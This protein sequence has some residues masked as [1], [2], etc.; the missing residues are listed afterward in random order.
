MARTRIT[1]TDLNT[2]LIEEVY[3]LNGRRHRDANEGPAYS[4]CYEGK[5]I[6]EKYYWHG[7]L[8]RVDGPAVLVHNDEALEEEHYYRYGLLHRDPKEG[9]AFIV[10]NASGTL[11]LEESYHVKG[12]FYRD[13]ADGPHHISR[14]DDGRIEREH[15]TDPDRAAPPHRPSRSRGAPAPQRKPDP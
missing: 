11:L 15:Y 7:R 5:P 13:P 12:E 9:P 3:L 14:Y 2:G 4:M 8:H 10:R 6:E 1:R